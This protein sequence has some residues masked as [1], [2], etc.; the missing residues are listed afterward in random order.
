MFCRLALQLSINAPKTKWMR[1]SFNGMPEKPVV[2]R[3]LQ[4]H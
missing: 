4:I 2:V 3:G 1:Q